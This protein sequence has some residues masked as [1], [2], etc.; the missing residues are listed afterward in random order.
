MLSFRLK[1]TS[2]N[3]VDT[4]FKLSFSQ[5]IEWFAMPLCLHNLSMSMVWGSIQCYYICGKLKKAKLYGPFLWM[6]F[7]CLKTTEPLWG[8]NLLLV[9]RTSWY[10]HNRPWK[11]KKLSWSWSHLAVLNSRPL[12][13]VS[14]ILITRPLHL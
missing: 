5:I 2:K 8:D 1:K 6:G 13:R 9:P 7:N 3:I 11:S 12:D 10:S 4:T 14:S